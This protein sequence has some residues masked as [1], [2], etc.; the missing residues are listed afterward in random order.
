MTLQQQSWNSVAKTLHWLIFFM[1]LVEV[2]AGFLMANLYPFGLKYQDVTPLAHLLAQIHHTNGF[3]L[4]GV[5]LARLGWRWTHPAP[6]LPQDL[7][8][9]Q[10]RVARGVQAML[11]VVLL[12]LP[13][14]GWMALSVLA[15]SAAFGRTQ[16]WFFNSDDLIPRI[17]E[18][19]PFNDPQGYGF[20]AQF[21][22]W[23]VYT[24]AALLTI[25]L[26]AALAHHFWRR[27]GVLAG[28]WPLAGAHGSPDSKAGRA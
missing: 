27:D 9:L 18:P 23:L 14:S 15:D 20:V 17:L 16:I 21:H 24:G 6:S 25:H 12:S 13:V 8:T 5:M 2:P 19:K 7:A 11:Y 1:V 3:L 22:R 4:L 10:R 26:A 28:M